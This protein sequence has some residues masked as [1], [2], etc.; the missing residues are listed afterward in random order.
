MTLAR[1]IATGAIVAAIVLVAVV[2]LGGDDTTTYKLRFVNASQLV[3][4]N[5]VQIGGRRIG[6][7]AEIELTE[8]NE[9]LVTIEVQEPYAPLHEGTTA[10]IR[11]TSLSGVANRYIQLAPGPND[12]A[13]LEEGT[14]LATAATTSTVDLDSLFNT[15]DPQTRK[16]L[17]DLIK[18][19]AK[20]YAGVA[21]EANEAAKYFNPALSSTSRL[22]TALA[23]DQDAFTKLVVETSKV[24]TALAERRDDLSGL[25]SNTATTMKAI[26]DEN[27]AL[28]DSLGRLPTVLRR[29]NTTFVNLRATLDDL[30]VLVA[31]SKPATKRLAEQLEQL[32]PLVRDAVPTVKDLSLLIRRPGEGNDLTELLRQAPQLERVAKPAF[33]NT[34]EALEDSLPVIKFIRPYT[35]DL[36]GWIRDFGQGAASYDANGHYAR[37]QPIFNAFNLTGNVLQPQPPANRLDGLQTGLLRRCPGSASQPAADG[38]AP[39]S[40][41]GLDC[42]TSDVI[43]GP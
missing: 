26:G 29:A 4:D 20:Q 16:G 37:I 42:S 2:L 19:S 14:E 34:I 40:E 9:A 3:K 33:A 43:K 15:L 8:N 7:V 38:S 36:M 17:Q 24:M 10:T 30:D 11:L 39:Y 32:R 13:E 5:D 21:D 18:G 6:R 35:P 28:S 25:V 27:V 41:P 12:R 22:T 1:G 23:G 31:E